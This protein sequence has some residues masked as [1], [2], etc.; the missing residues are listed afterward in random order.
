MSLVGVG[1]IPGNGYVGF[2]FMEIY[3]TKLVFYDPIRQPYIV[4]DEKPMRLTNA[5]NKNTP[6]QKTKKTTTTK[7]K[8]KKPQKTQQLHN[9]NQHYNNQQQHDNTLH[10]LHFHVYIRYV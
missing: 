3:H 6:P 1:F 10:S 4:F 8:N 7:N 2:P 9:N 5:K